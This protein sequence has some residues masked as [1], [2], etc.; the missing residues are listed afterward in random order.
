MR[1]EEM[2][3]MGILN[4]FSLKDRVAIVTGS[5]SGLGKAI[6]VG[7]ARAGANIVVVEIKPEAGM[8]TVEE[9]RALGRK[10]LPLP[11]DVL[12]S[13]QVDEMVAKTMAE[14]GK[15]DILVNNVGGSLQSRRVPIL[16][17]KEEV[18]DKIIAINLKSNFLCTKAVAKVMMEQKR[19]NIINLASVSGMRPYPSQP[20]YGASKA[21]VI[22]FTQS[23]AVQLA[24]YNIRVN[25]IA[26]GTIATPTA[27]YLGDRDERARKRGTLM[28]R[29][30]RIEDTVPAAIYLASDA[31]SYVTGVTIEVQGGPP[32]SAFYLE[33][34]EREWQLGLKSA[35]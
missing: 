7:F 18:W 29:A 10:A 24:P 20:P 28:R 6:S 14:F 16:E 19:G 35:K 15:M 17:L 9:I 1:Q 27:A 8:A 32:F 25:A 12:D 3:D 26:P 31:S 23:M 21:A 4:K 5:G 13:K 33:E 22:N 11:I 34:A 30:G 2:K